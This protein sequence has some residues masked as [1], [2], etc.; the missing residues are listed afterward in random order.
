MRM[1][2]V[3]P[4][5]E[6]SLLNGGKEPLRI[7]LI[8]VAGSGMSG[9]A[10]L[11]MGLG[12]RVSGSDKVTT[13]ETERMASVGLDFSCPHSAKAVGGAEVVIYS[14]AVKAGN[15]AFDAAVEEGI[16]LVRRAEVDPT[17]FRPARACPDQLGQDRFAQLHLVA[18]VVEH[19]AAD[20]VPVRPL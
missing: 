7:H 2:D 4:T 3:K 16:P 1:H 14:T 20:V 10:S 8:G 15:K 17:A 19:H 6:A 11:L 18:L 9:L 12:H 5:L 13:V